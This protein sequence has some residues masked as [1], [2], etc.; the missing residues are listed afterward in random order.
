MKKE[1]EIIL[2]SLDGFK[3]PKV[4]LEQYVTP[5]NLAGFVVTMAKLFGD[6]NLVV[7]LG[8]GTGILAI[9]SAILGAYSIGVDI[10]LDAIRIAKENAKRVGVK[11]DFVVCNVSD[12]WIKKKCTVLMNPPFGIKK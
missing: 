4:E 3:N 7:D 11:V 5:S 12:F 1:I 2:E 9:A 10:D 8:C 6:L